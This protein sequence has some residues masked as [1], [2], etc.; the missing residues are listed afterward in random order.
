[1]APKAPFLFKG[2]MDEDTIV[3]LA[4]KAGEA[5]INIIKISGKDSLKIIS[6]LFVS[7]SGKKI[8]QLKTY[9]M[10]YGHLLDENNE[11]IDEAIVSV[12]K[13]PKS[14][15]RE[16]VV[17]I[18]CHGGVAS[19]N[20]VMD[21]VV[22]NGARLAEPGEFTKRAF[23]NGRIDLS[24]AEAIAEIISAKNIE[25]LRI[26]ASN[27]T[28]K[29]KNE[30]N[31]IRRELLDVISNL[32]ASI[33]FI[34]EDLE[35]PPYK[36]IMKNLEE[37]KQKLT[38]L[39][40]NE[41]RGEIIKSGIKIAIVGRP[42][43]GK[44]SL[45]NLIVGKEK[46]IVTHIPGTTRDII[47]ETINIRGVPIIFSDTA[48]IR[49]SKNL[50]EKIGVEK[51]YREIEKSEIIIVLLDNSKKLNEEDIEILKETEHKKRIIC[52]NKMDLKSNIEKEKLKTFTENN[53]IM[54]SVT[55]KSGID[56]LE[57][58]I[59]ELAIGKDS[60]LYEDKVIVNKRQRIL[61]EKVDE[62]IGDAINAMKLNYSEEFPLTDLKI[63][64]NTIGEIIGENI[65]DDVL[66][67]IF[68][69]FC[70]GK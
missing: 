48:G 19:V 21:L 57:E 12:M 58:K 4:T 42:N 40:E 10:V 54:I 28:G 11:I 64:Y 2:K 46:A 27:L 53:F 55:K 20:K 59:R 8:N 31:N 16:D 39:I 17:E 26:A 34:E 47:E 45:L 43:V 14:Y 29:T 18:N 44:S 70:V 38:E 33:D 32:E 56:L 23:L 41:K 30:I 63:A 5:A 3:A 37:I 50:I 65:R 35:I 67:R 52:I 68:S 7:R 69:K 49:K 13:A 51:S 25:S 6:N 61:L 1:M 62:L 15:T 24:Q 9:T 60:F 22:K 66:D 36:E